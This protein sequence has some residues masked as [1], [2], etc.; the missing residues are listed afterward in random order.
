MSYGSRI[1]AV[2]FGISLGLAS[3][4]SAHATTVISGTYTYDFSLPNGASFL[5]TQS[6]PLGDPSSSTLSTTFTGSPMAGYLVTGARSG[7]GDNATWT[8][9][10]FEYAEPTAPGSNTAASILSYTFTESDTFWAE[11][12]ETSFPADG[13]TT[14]G[15]LLY[16]N[17]NVDGS[18]AGNPSDPNYPFYDFID[19]TVNQGAYYDT[20]TPA[21]PG[22][23][24]QCTSC[25]VNVTFTPSVASAV[26]EPS[27][28][29]L[30]GTG[31]AAI[32]G[33]YR[34]R[35]IALGVA[36]AGADEFDPHKD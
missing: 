23:D 2:L 34:R 32:V 10:Q 24:P 26:P 33:V 11:T 25:S 3:S 14:Y 12:G 21:G 30:L 17:V 20:Y 6:G 19:G 28:M 15:G 4:G 22:F 16:L 9:L 5:L 13:T 7:T 35:R 18:F 27:T 8:E 29:T 36:V 1:A 31:M